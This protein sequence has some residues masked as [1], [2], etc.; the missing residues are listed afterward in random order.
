MLKAPKG[1]A[2]TQEWFKFRDEVWLPAHSES[3]SSLRFFFGKKISLLLR[4]EY[5][6]Y[7]KFAS[8]TTIK[9]IQ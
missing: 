3:R 4:E 2:V 8:E 6:E 5:S 7:K 9:V 1:G